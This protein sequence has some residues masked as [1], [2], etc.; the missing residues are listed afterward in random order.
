[1]DK[2]DKVLNKIN[3]LV[4]DDMEVMRS[5]INYSLKDIG[6]ENTLMATNGEVAWDMLNAGRVDL[7]ICDWDMPQ[8]TGIELLR[9][10]KDSESLKDIPFLMLTASTEKDNIV[11]AIRAG[12]DDYLTKPF[13]SQELE[14]RVIKLLRKIKFK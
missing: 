10:M 4:A 5:M 6:V 2:L 3:V 12:V 1:M 7:I 8:M 11:M 13:Q 14:T 9:R